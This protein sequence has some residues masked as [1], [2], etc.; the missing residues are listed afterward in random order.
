MSN[1]HQ[2]NIPPAE[3][4]TK[5]LQAFELGDP[6]LVFKEAQDLIQAYR[7]LLIEAAKLRFQVNFGT[8]ACAHCDGLHAGPRV[9]A[10]C[11]QMQQ[12]NYCNL[13]EGAETPHQAAILKNFQNS[14]FGFFIHGHLVTLS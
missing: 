5:L 2:P 3:I 11:F 14:V 7:L 1:G 9:V 12:C 8:D 4:G 10:T 6:E 13:K